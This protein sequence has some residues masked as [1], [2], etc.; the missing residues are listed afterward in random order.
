[1]I[2]ERISLK[3][4]MNHMSNDLHFNISNRYRG[5]HLDEGTGFNSTANVSFFQTSNEGS[6]V[7][8]ATSSKFRRHSDFVPRNFVKIKK[9]LPEFSPKDEEDK[10]FKFKIDDVLTRLAT[11][12]KVCGVTLL[13]AP[14][15]SNVIRTLSMILEGK[16]DIDQDTEEL[17][18]VNAEVN[19]CITMTTPSRRKV[20][21]E[22]DIMSG[23]MCVDKNKE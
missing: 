5:R 17:S 11:E 3:T 7:L 2:K 21:S 14:T 20:C 4:A 12:K 13:D 19:F 23:D 8:V 10:D 16:Y 9:M 15:E 22:D 1:M 18:L 6:K